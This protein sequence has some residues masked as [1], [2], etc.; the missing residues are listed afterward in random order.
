MAID[1]GVF[2]LLRRGGENSQ[3]HKRRASWEGHA[4]FY[5]DGAAVA[6]GVGLQ[7]E[8]GALI[9]STL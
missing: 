3:Q 8:S 5:R 9:D 2:R 4:V 1:E 7:P 6:D